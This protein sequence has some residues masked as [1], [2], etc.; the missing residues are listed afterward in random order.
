MNWRAIWN[1]VRMSPVTLRMP[2]LLLLL[3]VPLVLMVGIP[4]V[5]RGK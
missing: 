2:H 1:V 5:G 4:R 3:I